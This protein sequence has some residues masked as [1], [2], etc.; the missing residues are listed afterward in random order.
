MKYANV[1]SILLLIG[2]LAGCGGDDDGITPPPPPPPPVYMSVDIIADAPD[3]NSIDHTVWDAVDSTDILVGAYPATYG[4]DAR[5]GQQD[6]VLKAIRKS[7]ILYLYARWG[8]DSDPNRVGNSMQ[9]S[10]AEWYHFTSYGE[11]K[12]MLVFDAGNNGDEKADCASM[13]HQT[14]PKHKTTGGGNADVWV[15]KSSTTAPAYLGEDQWWSASGF[16]GDELTNPLEDSVYIDNWNSP[17]YEY[18]YPNYMH[19]TVEAYEDT[20]LYVDDTTVYDYSNNWSQGH[21]MPGWVIDSSY[22]NNATRESRWDILSYSEHDPADDTWEVVL[23]RAL[24]TGNA[25]DVDMSAVDTIQVTLGINHNHPAYSTEPKPNHSG[26]L[27]FYIIL[28]P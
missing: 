24:N 22:H 3:M 14:A 5:L 6:V 7:D 15:W 9:R 11:D 17:G 28:N 23:A 12:L 19:I 8:N 13:C 20:F 1:I 2:L 16:A 21:L 10:A 4:R 25:D 18:G 26:S 27:P